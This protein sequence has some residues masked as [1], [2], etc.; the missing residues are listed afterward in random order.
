MEDQG[1]SAS[2]VAEEKPQVAVTTAAPASA[3]PS[4]AA[5][6]VIDAKISID[7]FA[8]VELRVGQVKVAEKV[9][10]ADKFFGWK[11]TWAQ[12][13]DRSSPGSQKLTFPKP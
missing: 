1:R 3:T 5:P 9:K 4:S 10:N 2:G 11:W 12:K 8:K 6:T 13:Y 7:D